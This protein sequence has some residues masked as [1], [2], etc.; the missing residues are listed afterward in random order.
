[1]HSRLLRQY[2]DGAFDHLGTLH[3]VCCLSR[4]KELSL[5]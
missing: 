5:D 1:M 4:N 3:I 2:V